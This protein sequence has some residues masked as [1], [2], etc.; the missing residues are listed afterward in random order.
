MQENYNLAWSDQHKDKVSNSKKSEQSDA[1]LIKK[2]IRRAASIRG[3][4]IV[5]KLPYYTLQHDDLII[6]FAENVQMLSSLGARVIIVHGYEEIIDIK[7]KE[8]GVSQREQVSR[9]SHEKISEMAEMIIS[10]RINRDII[11]KLCLNGVNTI[12]FSGKDANLIIAEKPRV[13]LRNNNTNFRFNYVGT[14]IR[15]NP[16]LLLSHED[17]EITAVI[18][19]V[20]C[21]L[22]GRTVI[23]DPYSTAAMI[24]ESV[25]A[26]HFIMLGSDYQLQQRFVRAF[27]SQSLKK[28]LN[29]MGKVFDKHCSAKL[30]SKYFIIARRNGRAP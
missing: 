23:L 12:G 27:D 7:L 14:P 24:V 9:F 19:P 2:V 13:A 21:S 16:D 30:S 3:Q 8:F 10:G 15:V 1:A 26:D 22:K 28:S 6:N 25:Q 29:I 5:V 20:A 11:T 17:S 4:L 18:S